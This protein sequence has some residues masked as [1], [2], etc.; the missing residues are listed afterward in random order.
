MMESKDGFMRKLR[1]FSIKIP[2]QPCLFMINSRPCVFFKSSHPD[3]LSQFEYGKPG[4]EL[5]VSFSSLQALFRFYFPTFFLLLA[6]SKT[7]LYSLLTFCLYKEKQE[8]ACQI[9][10]LLYP[11]RGFCHAIFLLTFL[12]PKRRIKMSLLARLQNTEK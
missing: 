8:C 2:R 10:P 6:T 12:I 11:S 9:C 7:E 1:F 5:S 3:E 4:F